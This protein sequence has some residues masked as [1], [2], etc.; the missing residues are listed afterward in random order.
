MLQLV[1]DNVRCLRQGIDLIV[2]LPEGEYTRKHAACFGSTIGGHMRHNID[3][4]ERFAQGWSTGR[5]DYDARTRD[6]QVE[7]DPAAAAATMSALESALEQ[8]TDDDLDKPV[9]VIMDSGGDPALCGPGHS[10]VRRELQFLLSHTVHHY[11]LIAVLCQLRG[12]ETGPSFGVAPSTLRYRG[13][14]SCAR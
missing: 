4:Y 12:I 11:A 6:P 1:H 13:Q 14:S 10:S 5:I 9:E 2:A 3:H 7:T 8:L